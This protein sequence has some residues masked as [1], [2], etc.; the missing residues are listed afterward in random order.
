[1]NNITSSVIV[2]PLRM[3]VEVR[4]VSLDRSKERP[5]VVDLRRRVPHR[6]VVPDPSRPGI[7]PSTRWSTKSTTPWPRNSENE[8]NNLVG[9][10][11]SSNSERQPK[12][13]W[14]VFRTHFKSF[15]GGP[16]V[17]GP[18]FLEGGR[19]GYMGSDKDRLLSGFGRREPKEL[20][21]RTATSFSARSYF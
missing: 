2:W 7:G 8:K 16:G 5:S 17:V 1:M 10:L 4:G 6:L 20:K 11:A 14:H 15:R 19:S 13:F 3:N 9:C 12:S 18:F 21:R